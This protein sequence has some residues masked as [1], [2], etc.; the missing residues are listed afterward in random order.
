[1]SH[2]DLAIENSEK[3]NNSKKCCIVAQMLQELSVISQYAT[4]VHTRPLGTYF[5]PITTQKS[6]EDELRVMEKMPAVIALCER[7]WTLGLV[8]LVGAALY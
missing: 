4:G 5:L 8:Q 2:A 6:A 1:M 7:I 3:E